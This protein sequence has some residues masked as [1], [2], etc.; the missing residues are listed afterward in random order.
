DNVTA[1]R[2]GQWKLH[3]GKREKP[4]KSPMLYNVVK[5]PYEAQPLNDQHP[6]VVQRLLK[7]IDDFQAQIPKV[8]SLQYPVR[9]PA[10]RKSGVRRK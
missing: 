10:K 3:V 8:W 9:D 7:T 4:L 2:D 1:I 5:D 6:Q